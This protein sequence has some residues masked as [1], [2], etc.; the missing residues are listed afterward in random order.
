MPNG[1]AIGSTSLTGNAGKGQNAMR[2]LGFSKKWDKLQ[3]RRFTTFRFPRRDVDWQR[4]EVVQVV[5][6]PRSP[7]REILGT[8]RIIEK[9]LRYMSWGEAD[10]PAL[11]VTNEEA[12]ADGFPDG[13]DKR[14]G[15][16]KKGYF[17]MWEF[18]FNTYG[19]RRL[20]DEPMNKLTLQ[21][22]GK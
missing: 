7:K 1:L 19:G 11:I 15:F 2:I 22:E 10:P 3:Q 16:P 12:N 14:L 20:V 6:K 21:W 4:W 17:F 9:G 8:A 18:L 5:Y 13:E